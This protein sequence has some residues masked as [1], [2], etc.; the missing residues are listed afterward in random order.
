MG[1]GPGQ[2]G[3]LIAE[4]R[5]E[6]PD[7]D[8]DRLCALGDL[9]AGLDGKLRGEVGT[10]DGRLREMILGS[11]GQS[12]AAVGAAWTAPQAPSTNL[13][14]GATAA[15]LVALGL[16]ACAGVVIAL[17]SN[18]AVQLAALD[19]QIKWAEDNA[20]RTDG[21]S[22][23]QIPEFKADAVQNINQLVAEAERA[24]MDD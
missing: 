6:W 17:K 5:L 13:E 8:E 22:L 10:A 9:W 24:I 21:A 16:Y 4:L 15:T 12:V 19:S 3:P 20:T 2:W 1:M 23:D 7:T 18:F 14:H 11:Q